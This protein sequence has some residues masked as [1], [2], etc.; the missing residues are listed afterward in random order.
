VGQGGEVRGR[1]AGLSREIPAIAGEEFTVCPHCEVPRPHSVTL[2]PS[3]RACASA[4]LASS[5]ERAATTPSGMI[6]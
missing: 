3:S 2:T 1:Q 5:I 6:W 4:S